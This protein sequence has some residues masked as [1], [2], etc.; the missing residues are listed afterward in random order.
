MVRG[1]YVALDQEVYAFAGKFWRTTR[2][3][4]IPFDH[5]LVHQPKTEFEGVWV[6]HDDEPRKLPLGVRAS[7]LGAPVSVRGRG[8]DAQTRRRA[9]ARFTIVPLTG[10]RRPSTDARLRR[11]R[12]RAGGCATRRH[13]DA[14]RPAAG[15]SQARRE[16]DRRRTSRRRRSSPTRATSRSSRR[17]SRRGRHDDDDK[18]KDHRTPTGSF[19]IREKHIAATMD[20]DVATRRPVLDRGRAR[21]SCTSEGATRCTAP[22]GTRTSATS[23][24]TAA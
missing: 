6:G 21:G 23:R 4:Y 16:V 11:D 15:R 9:V 3:S 14:P 7:Q 22:S 8:Q 19:R 24:A 13:V 18:E 17:S 2:G 1:F 12:P 10:K 5:I 20:G